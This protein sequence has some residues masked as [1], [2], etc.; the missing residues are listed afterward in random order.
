MITPIDIKGKTLGFI[1][2]RIGGRKEN[3]DS[4]GIKDTPLGYL[5]VVCDGMGGMRLELSNVFIGF[6]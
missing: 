1:D 4:A 3:Q 2:S 6:P 5:V